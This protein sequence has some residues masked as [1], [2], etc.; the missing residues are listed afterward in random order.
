MKPGFYVVRIPRR[1][2]GGKL[3]IESICFSTERDREFAKRG[4][5]NW[6]D[7]VQSQHPKDEVFVIESFGADFGAD[8]G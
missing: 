4:A 5:H 2:S 6:C 3:T 1:G 7:F 8:F